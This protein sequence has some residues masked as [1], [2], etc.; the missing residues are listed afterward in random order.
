MITLGTVNISEKTKQLMQ[1]ALNEGLIGQGKYVAEFEKKLADFLSVKYVIST[2]SGTMADACALAAIKEQDK[3]KRNEVIVPALTFIAQV[4]SI[5]YNHLQPVFVDV[6]RDF[7]I[8]VSK[9]EE[10]ITKNTLAIMPVHLFGWPA[11]MDAIKEI[12][13]KHN[14]FI[15]EDACEALG[16]KYKNEFLGTIGNM[17]TFSFYVSHSITT[18]EGGAVATND[19]QLA[20]LAYSLRNHGRKS[21]I[22]EEKFIFPRIG[23]SAKMNSMEAIVGLGIIDDL[24][25]YVKAR[26]DNMVQINNLLQEKH[27]LEKENEYVAPHCLPFLVSSKEK[28]D[29]L[30][31]LIPGKYEIE[32]RQAFYS[33][34]TQSGAYEFLGQK[35]GNYP[36]AED[37]GNRG[38]YLPCHQNLSD[39]DVKKIVIALNEAIKNG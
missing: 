15:V 1:E 7:Q 33:I 19:E 25:G 9:I 31:K 34:P 35:E 27:F 37:I 29:E 17:G 2:S 38:L 3:L 12:A 21:D 14:I 28:R 23:F 6:G 39:E 20:G 18:G 13:K 4:N 24:S 30:L 10:K 5:Y 36:V 26:H 32:A 16:S 22:I 11:N 8:D